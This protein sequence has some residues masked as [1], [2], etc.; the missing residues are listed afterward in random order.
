MIK[1][2]IIR[3][4]QMY[5]RFFPVALFL[6]RLLDAIF[7]LLGYWLIA[8]YLFNNK[9]VVSQVEVIDYFTFAAAGMLYYNVAV[10][11]LMNVGRS[12]MVEV[13]E[14]T[15]ESLFI[16]PYSIFS[17]YI[18]VFIE[19]LGRTFMEFCSLFIISILLGAK[20]MATPISYWLLSYVVIVLI[21]FSMSVF[22]ANI[23]LWLR[24]TFIS[25]NTL[26][27]LIFLVSG[28]TFPRTVLLD[29]LKCVGDLLPITYGLEIVRLISSGDLESLQLCLL[30]FKV[31]LL[32]L[33]FIVI[34]LLSYKKVEKKV[35]EYL[36]I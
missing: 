19:Q 13:R 3:N 18:G 27:I 23:M 4:L 2:L 9:L 33:V 17:Y 36:T 31:L 22:V 20:F 10:A 24:D 15:L 12:L 28:V 32:S 14:G 34:G 11:I 8:H 26:F 35:I 7:Q 29:F 5:T 21:L 16:T 30:I 25:Q 6:N 1:A